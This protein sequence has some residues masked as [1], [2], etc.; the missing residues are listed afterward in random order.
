MVDHDIECR[1]KDQAIPTLTRGTTFSD[2]EQPS[3]AGIL[4]RRLQTF[5][6]LAMQRSS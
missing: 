4:E 6:Y 5:G 1:Q 3:L 2:I